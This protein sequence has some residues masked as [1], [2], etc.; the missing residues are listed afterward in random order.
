[1]SEIVSKVM[2]MIMIIMIFYICTYNVNISPLWILNL[3]R[4]LD[5]SFYLLYSFLS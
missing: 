5:F 4:E 2:I 3:V 1:M